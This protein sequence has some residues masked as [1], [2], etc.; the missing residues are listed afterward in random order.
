MDDSTDCITNCKPFSP[1]AQMRILGQLPQPL[2]QRGKK[3]AHTID[4]Q[5]G[6]PSE[7]D[8]LSAT[9]IAD[10]CMT[11]DA[12]A[13][14]FMASGLEK[15]KEIAKKVPGLFYYFIYIQPDGTM[16]TTC[17]EGFE[18]FFAE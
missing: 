17:S 18:Q 8:I 10:D 3:Y 12:Y 5:T 15:S 13:T 4:P 9:V 7:Q 16:A 1:F 11:A 2:R 6:Y 14:A